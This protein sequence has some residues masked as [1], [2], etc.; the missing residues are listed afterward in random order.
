MGPSTVAIALTGPLDNPRVK[1]DDG[2]LSK[3]LLAA[4]KQRAVDEASKA[5]TKLL[6]EK[7]G[8]DLGNQGKSL[9]NNILGGKKNQP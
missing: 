6:D 5:A 9:L 4:G 3:A 8:G 1:V 7:V 2:G